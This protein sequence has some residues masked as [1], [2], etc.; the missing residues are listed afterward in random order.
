MIHEDAAHLPGGHG[1]EMRAVLPG[2]VH[3]D[4]LHERF[5]DDRGRLQRVAGTLA[6]HVAAGPIAQLFIISGVSR[7][8]ARESPDCHADNSLVTACRSGD[9]MAAAMVLL[10]GVLRL[11][12]LIIGYAQSTASGLH[13][14]LRRLRWQTRDRGYGLPESAGPASALG[15][16]PAG[17]ESMP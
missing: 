13:R 2:H 15:V 10:S 6:T 8:S 11:G 17:R 5:V 9:G 1:K 4:E 14:R 7:S 16:F 12:R 3:L